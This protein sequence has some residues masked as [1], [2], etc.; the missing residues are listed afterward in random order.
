MATTVDVGVE[1]TGV[2]TIPMQPPL[3]EASWHP[4]QQP[5]IHIIRT[6]EAMATMVVLPTGVPPA[7]MLGIDC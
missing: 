3:Q 7:M 1:I 6:V 4:M 2:Q 5:A